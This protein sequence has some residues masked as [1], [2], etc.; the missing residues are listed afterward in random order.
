MRPEPAWGTGENRPNTAR[1]LFHIM[2]SGTDI[3][4]MTL[5]GPRPQRVRTAS[6]GVGVLDRTM[7]IL[8]AVEHGARSFTAI[9][10]ATGYTRPTAHRLIK[11]MDDHGLLTLD[12]GR[13]YRL[14]PRLL[15]LVMAAARNLPL[16]D[17]ARP[18]LQRLAAASG[19]SAQLYVLDGDRRVCIDAAESSNELRT[20]VSVGASLP[21]TRGSAGKV[22]LAWIGAP[23]R[24]L[25]LG[26]LEG[27]DPA[28]ATHLRQQVGTARRRG[29]ADSVGERESGVASVS[30]PVIDRLGGL[31][32]VVSVS[33]PAGRIGTAG[34][35]RYAPAVTAAAREI[36]AS[37]GA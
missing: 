14:G 27:D 23:H 37:L 5:P 31:V 26:A 2:E 21:L 12:G 1:S 10:E 3:W 20:I 16:R 7:A 30:A 6:S 36:E 28:A 35:K 8:D 29:W 13:G 25:I 11:A 32:A 9:V 18:A 15:G 22:F 33:G 4:N 17:L 19:E 34:G 24:E